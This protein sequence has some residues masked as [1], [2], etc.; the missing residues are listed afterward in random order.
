MNFY[1][2]YEL[3]EPLPGEGP[4]SFRARQI[5][6]RREVTVHLLVGG[7][8]P[9]NRGLLARLRALPPDS[10]A[11]MLEVGN[12][13]GTQY[14]V[15]AAPPFQHLLAWI[16]DQE[17]AALAAQKLGRAGTWKVPVAQPPPAPAPPSLATADFT[18][19]FVSPAEPTIERSAPP[20]PPP[21]A[22]MAPPAQSQPGEFTR[23]FQAANPPAPTSQHPAVAPP[24]PPPAAPMAPPAQSQPGEFTRLFQAAA[25]PTAPATLPN[26]T[27]A[28]SM[29]A[30][31]ELPVAPAAPPPPPVAAAPSAPPAQSQP[32]E[33]TRLFQAASP[34]PAAQP[35]ESRPGEFTRMF[36]SPATPPAEQP[37]PPPPAASG[38][39]GE[40][41]RVFNSPMPSAPAAADW[42]PP[43]PPPTPAGTFTQ[44]FQSPAPAPPAPESHP[45]GGEF[46][47]FFHAS[48]L[49][50]QGPALPAASGFPSAPGPSAAPPPPPRYAV[51]G[52]AT[53]AFALPS[54][55]QPAGPSAASQGPGEYTR[56]MSVSSSPAA[57][58][59]A[60]PPAPGT[61]PTP[62]M[63]QMGMP[64]MP[65]MPAMA[66]PPVPQPPP[67]PHFAAPPPPQFAVPAPQLSVPSPPVPAKAPD[68]N[69]LLIII[70]ALAMFLLGGLIVFL[71]VRH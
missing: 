49:G 15:T 50:T 18:Q 65:P 33:F 71:L 20:P 4:K 46:T 23:L 52:G 56:M 5:S 60:A 22:P 47:Q 32:G 42:S 34:T 64:A 48:P 63:P 9:E 14:V 12:H 41:T 67:A 53:Q 17:R 38:P 66:P 45:Q 43:P 27:A 57:G 8:T 55:P 69:I 24:P 40:F 16:D 70:V 68:T 6:L 11:K 36:Q 35:A 59:P 21:P 13:E 58:V 31:I 44:M 10:L 54:A 7:Q 30:T 25:P 51:S 28:D 29:E 26:L 37:A 2:K 19:P 1:Q 3:I 39:P 62:A 61:A